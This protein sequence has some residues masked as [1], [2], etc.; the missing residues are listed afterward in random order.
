MEA[1]A[2]DVPVGKLIAVLAEEGDDLSSL[3][4]P[5]EDEP[6]PKASSSKSEAKEP[7]KDEAKDEKAKAMKTDGYAVADQR[8]TPTPD[9][10]PAKAHH[11]HPKHPQPLLP[12][13][14]FLLAQEGIEDATKI[15]A[16]GKGG[17]L[18][19]S[20]VLLHLGR[21]KDVR[22]TDTAS[23]DHSTLINHS[24]KPSKG[25]KAAS[26]PIEVLD[27][28]SFRRLVLAGLS[29]A[30]A[31]LAAAAQASSGVPLSAPK[32][33]GFDDILKGYTPAPSPAAKLDL[34]LAKA[35]RISSGLSKND[36]LR[37]VLEA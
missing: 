26:A 8:E 28:P 21:L 30:P 14:L 9:A 27:G 1:G 20:D 29:S 5:S 32:L 17:R 25:K 23:R 4:I 19:K 36:P 16:T 12:S 24:S 18:T 13:V 10:S 22:G 31:R 15:K 11:V 37:Q 33:I 3:E 7:A 2:S 6:K 35:P 34:S